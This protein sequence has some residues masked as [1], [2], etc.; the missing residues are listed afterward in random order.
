MHMYTTRGV[1]YMFSTKRVYEWRQTQVKNTCCWLTLKI[2]NCTSYYQSWLLACTWSPRVT[3]LCK[4]SYV[5]QAAICKCAIDNITGGSDYF[6]YLVNNRQRWWLA[7]I[8]HHIPAPNH[9]KITTS[10]AKALAIESDYCTV[11]FVQN[12]HKR[13]SIDRPYL[14]RYGVSFVTL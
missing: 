7:V 13:H 5:I 2:T 8:Y 11:I 3:A 9:H 1:S 14:W 6:N 12:P 10:H 4:Q